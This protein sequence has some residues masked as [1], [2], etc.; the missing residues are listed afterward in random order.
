MEPSRTDELQR[1]L[2][3]LIRASRREE[4]YLPLHVLAETIAASLEPGE[5][6]LLAEF[7]LTYEEEHTTSE[8]RA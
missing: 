7:I 2:A 5:H 6:F 4:S 1:D 3:V 8:V